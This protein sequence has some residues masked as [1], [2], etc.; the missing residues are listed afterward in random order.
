MNYNDIYR[1]LSRTSFSSKMAKA[2]Y[3]SIATMSA[4]GQVDPERMIALWLPDEIETFVL[5][6]ILAKEYDEQSWKKLQAI[7][8]LDDWGYQANVRK[9]ISVL[10]DIKDIM[11]N[12]EE[13]VFKVLNCNFDTQYSYPWD[14]KF[15]IEIRII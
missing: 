11:K 12:Y 7:R 15:E 3:A 4:N 14:R 8:L 13:R 10:S 5:N 2:F 1:P 6:S 9:R